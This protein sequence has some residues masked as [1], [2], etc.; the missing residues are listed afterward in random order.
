MEFISGGRAGRS[1]RQ[2]VYNIYMASC[3]CTF[4][5][6]YKLAKASAAGCCCCEILFDM[7]L[8]FSYAQRCRLELSH[9]YFLCAL[10]LD[11]ITYIHI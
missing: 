8:C 5:Q 11:Y 10:A 2:K 4:A 6:I 7:Y 1:R 9:V 3:I